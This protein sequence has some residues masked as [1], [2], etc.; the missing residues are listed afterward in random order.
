MLVSQASTLRYDHFVRAAAYWQQ[1]ADPDGAED[2]E[3]RRRDKRDVYLDA[4]FSGMWFGRMTLD[5]ISGTVV[6]TELERLERG[7]FEADWAQARR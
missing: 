5:P 4:S 6:S 1:L 7:L 2:D 3:E